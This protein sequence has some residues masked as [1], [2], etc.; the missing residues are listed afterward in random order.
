MNAW[1]AWRIEDP[2]KPVLLSLRFGFVWPPMRVMEARCRLSHEPPGDRCICG[3]HAVLRATG[4]TQMLEGE[5]LEGSGIVVGRVALAGKIVVDPNGWLR[6]ESAYPLWLVVVEQEELPAFPS[7]TIAVL[8][9]RKYEVP[10]EAMLLEA[11]LSGEG[12]SS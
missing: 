8:L 7:R 5:A 1:R 3:I 2:R 10:A 4:I 11:F 12:M 6:G 9:E